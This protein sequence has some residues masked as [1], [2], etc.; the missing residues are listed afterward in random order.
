MTCEHRRAA[1]DAEPW[2]SALLAD[3]RAWTRRPDGDGPDPVAGAE[4]LRSAPDPID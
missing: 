4:P 2:L 1:D 3:P